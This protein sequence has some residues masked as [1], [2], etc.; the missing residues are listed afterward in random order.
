MTLLSHAPQLTLH[1]AEQ[2]ARDLYGLTAAASP[3]PS[4]RD[5][6]FRLRSEDGRGLVL[7]VANATEARAMLAA[8]N[9]TMRQL[10]G[11]ELAPTLVPTLNGDDIGRYGVHDVRLVTALDGRPLGD[12]ARQSD[13]LLRDLG[14]AVGLMDRALEAFLHYTIGLSV[15]QSTAIV[16]A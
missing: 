5:Q 9:A 16:A 4:E 8:E 11:T 3:L 13:N 10:A 12:T 2:L 7:K 15:E 1:D 14:R 6:N